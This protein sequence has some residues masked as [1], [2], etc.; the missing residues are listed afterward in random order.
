MPA[1]GRD[2]IGPFRIFG[3]AHKPDFT[4]ADPTLSNHVRACH[5]PSHEQWSHL[6]LDGMPVTLIAVKS[7]EPGLGGPGSG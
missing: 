7:N 4:I 5:E 3:I 6:S 2:D 1:P